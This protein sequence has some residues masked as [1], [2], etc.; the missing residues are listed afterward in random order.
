MT[1]APA[2]S[3][4]LPVYN[5]EKYIREAVDSI[6][7]QSFTDF[8]C[9][10]I[11]DGSKDSSPTILDE[12]ALLDSR[13]RIVHQENRGLISSLNRGLS[14][15]RGELV[16][17]MD[18]DD[19]STPDRFQKQVEYMKQHPDVG[20][21]GGAITLIDEVG[22]VIRASDYPRRG[23]EMDSFIKRGSPVAHPAVMMR[24]DLALGLGGYRAAYQACEDYDLWLRLYEKADID[25]L[26]DN[27][28][29]YRQH[30]DKISFKHAHQ[31]AIGT[32]VARLAFESRQAGKLDPTDGL[33]TLD[34]NVIELFELEKDDKARI[35]LE[36]LEIKTNAL[37]LIDGSA[38][39]DQILAELSKISLGRGNAIRAR[40]YLK[41][42]REYGRGRRWERSA[43]CL[44]YAF[45]EAPRTCL[46][47]IFNKGKRALV[48]MVRR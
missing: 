8:E 21:L 6:L 39:L 45:I 16:A 44:F 26:P 11:N 32:I 31:Q 12:Y 42:A 18:A 10:L 47:L 2:I 20:L 37:S 34:A 19:I 30:D 43:R 1:L 38:A 40:I 24:R 25:N 48:K 14:E 29:Y 22:G 7:C 23:A 35:K 3:V 15:A 28:L 36:M 5:G 13:V 46:S 27:I 33:S 9:I 4:V 17:R 41:A